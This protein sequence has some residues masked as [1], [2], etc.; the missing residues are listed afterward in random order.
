MR[1]GDV[2]LDERCQGGVLLVPIERPRFVS[3]TI[4]PV[5][6]LTVRL[7]RSSHCHFCLCPWISLR[8]WFGFILFNITWSVR[9]LHRGSWIALH[10][11]KVIS[12]ELASCLHNGQRHYSHFGD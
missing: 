6:W 12:K 7:R 4:V 5:P 8:F 1:V 9:E 11:I 10:G 3:V 2:E